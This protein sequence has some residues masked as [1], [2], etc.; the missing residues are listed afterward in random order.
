MAARS[1]RL[2]AREPSHRDS[3]P[4]FSCISRRSPAWRAP[5]SA[6]PRRAC[7]RT[8]RRRWTPL[9]WWNNA[10]PS[11]T[12]HELYVASVN[13]P[14]IQEDRDY[15]NHD[16]TSACGTAPPFTYVPFPYP[17]PLATGEPIPDA[18]ISADAG[19]MESDAG[20]GRDAA[21]MDA[22]AGT[23]SSGCACRADRRGAAAPWWGML[24]ATTLVLRKRASRARQG[25]S[26]HAARG[27]CGGH[28]RR[29]HRPGLSHRSCARFFALVR[30]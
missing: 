1:G 10:D 30:W 4:S 5:R 18:G 9:Y 12:L 20:P 24:V 13:A 14:F 25:R 27:G 3:S 6:T 8:S 2:R 19:T 16:P 22:G 7:R 23:R 15:C 21:T 11:G 17:H 29:G 26:D 28:V